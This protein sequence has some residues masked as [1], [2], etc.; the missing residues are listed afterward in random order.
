MTRVFV[1]SP[2]LT[3]FYGE[4][5]CRTVRAYALN[6][7]LDPLLTATAHVSIAGP[8]LSE[9]LLRL[10]NILY[11]S[12]GVLPDW[13]GQ[14]GEPQGMSQSEVEIN[15]TAAEII[16]PDRWPLAGLR[17][18]PGSVFRQ[19]ISEANASAPCGIGAGDID[20]DDFLIDHPRG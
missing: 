19:L 6:T 20:D 1:Y 3:T 13:A 15:A 11:I 17:G 9:D 14:I 8:A 7:A 12:D 2:D 18:T 5:I 16:L 10:R 4:L